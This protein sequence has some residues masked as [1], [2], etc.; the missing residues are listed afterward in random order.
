MKIEKKKKK[1][2]HTRH[3]RHGRVEMV[4]CGGGCV[5]MEEVVVWTHHD[6]SGSGCVEMVQDGGGG[7]CIEMVVVVVEASAYLGLRKKKD[8]TTVTLFASG[9]MTKWSMHRSLGHRSPP[10]HQHLLYHLWRLWFAKPS[11]V[12]TQVNVDSLVMSPI[13]LVEPHQSQ[14]MIVWCSGNF[15]VFLPLFSTNLM[16]SFIFL[17]SK[18]A[19]MNWPNPP[20]ILTFSHYAILHPL[21]PPDSPEF[22]SGCLH[23]RFCQTANPC[24]PMMGYPEHSSSFPLPSASSS[25]TQNHTMTSLLLVQNSAGGCKGFVLWMLLSVVLPPSPLVDV[26]QTLK[27]HCY[28][29]WM[30]HIGAKQRMWQ[31][32]LGT[33]VLFLC[34]FLFFSTN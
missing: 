7:G 5:K 21:F 4:M 30:N 25:L 27:C 9:C 23:L 24:L 26:L 29:P 13:G 28:E 20:L 18:P 6:D 32:S 2:K 22:H 8:G 16:F 1:E 12:R 33:Q 10:F 11:V 19:I 17:G 34:T 3:R 14:M 15:F 31:M